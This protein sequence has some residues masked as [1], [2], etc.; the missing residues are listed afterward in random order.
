MPLAP[1]ETPVYVYHGPIVDRL[2]WNWSPGKWCDW[3]LF[4]ATLLHSALGTTKEPRRSS[5]GFPDWY[6]CIYKLAYVYISFFVAEGLSLQLSAPD[7][8][9][10]NTLKAYQVESSV[11]SQRLSVAGC[12]LLVACCRLLLV[13]E[14]NARKKIKENKK[15]C[16]L[17]PTILKK[18]QN[19]QITLSGRSCLDNGSVDGIE[20]KAGNCQ[21]MFFW[22][23]PTLFGHIWLPLSLL[24]CFHYVA[25]SAYEDMSGYIWF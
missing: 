5:E 7:S 19:N 6:I 20:I 1:F 13:A 12:K 11:C 16:W 4:A 17:W 14:A 9:K 23:W 10:R 22:A 3:K 21:Q 2:R 15:H 8:G 18:A 25:L 24:I